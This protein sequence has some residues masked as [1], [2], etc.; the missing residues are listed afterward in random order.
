MY[1]A[2]YGTYDGDKWEEFFQKV[3]KTKYDS[4]GYQE[5][6][7]RTDGD[8]GIEG[9]TNTGKVFQ[10]YCPDGNYESKKIYEAQ[11]DKINDD[12]N[13]LRKNKLKLRKFLIDVKI[14]EWIFIT[15]ETTNKNLIAYC[16]DKSVEFRNDPNMS[17]IIDDNFHVLVKD[18]DHF[19][20]EI[21]MIKRIE[22]ERIKIR[23]ENTLDEEVI[24]WRG[25]ES[26]SVEVITNK[27][28]HTKGSVGKKV[29][30]MVR[31]FIKGQKIISKMEES[32]PQLF[33]VQQRIK[34]A[35]ENQLPNDLLFNEL[36][37]I[38]FLKETKNKYREALESERF[39]ELVEYGVT[40]DLCQ[41]AI[42]DWL[43]RCPL[44]FEPEE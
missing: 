6:V 42:A 26:E 34:N 5:V 40:D 18:E 8:L 11:R 32:F 31:D 44:D 17:E 36:P 39:S 19:V 38:N 28:R 10:C 16:K 9:I 33:E 30:I 41:E 35:V 7:A 4:E 21:L 15:P 14:K 25:S 37:P 23:V 13:K 22:C 29:D 43:I 12:L 2:K 1:I 27:L 24:E 20:K 3:L